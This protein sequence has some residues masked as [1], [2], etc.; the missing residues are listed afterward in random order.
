MNEE[1]KEWKMRIKNS[2]RNHDSVIK[3][4]F[5]FNMLHY[6]TTRVMEY[7]ENLREPAKVRVKSLSRVP[8]SVFP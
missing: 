3:C 7:V 5:L 6:T 2:F 4:V 1:L 8:F